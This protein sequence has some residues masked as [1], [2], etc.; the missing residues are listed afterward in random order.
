MSSII[1]VESRLPLFS[2]EQNF[3]FL[4]FLPIFLC[5]IWHYNFYFLTACLF[6]AWLFW[7]P[8]SGSPPAASHFC[9]VHKCTHHFCWCLTSAEQSTL[10]LQRQPRA[11]SSCFALAQHYFILFN[12]CSRNPAK[13]FPTGKNCF[14]KSSLLSCVSA[15]SCSCLN[16]A[17]I[18]PESYPHFSDH[19]C[20]LS[21]PLYFNHLL[22]NTCHLLLLEIF[23]KFNNDSFCV[24]IQLFN[25]YY[26]IYSNP[27]WSFMEL[28]L[29]FW[30]RSVTANATQYIFSVQILTT[31]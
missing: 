2:S 6:S 31:S 14:E 20:N 11:A 3:I 10:H 17:L 9:C 22:C 18:R 12:L 16:E 30:Q 13:Y 25:E 28:I 26:K 1:N 27:L 15:I 5:Q 8:S 19:T 29:V 24:I 21:R 23:C 7:L 4:R